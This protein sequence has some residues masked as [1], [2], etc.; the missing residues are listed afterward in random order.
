V[1]KLKE[2]LAPYRAGISGAPLHS[3]GCRVMVQVANGSGAASVWLPD[4]WRVRGEQR[5]LDELCALPHVQRAA[6]RYD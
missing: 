6:F 2:S 4:S 5:L 3:G 1:A